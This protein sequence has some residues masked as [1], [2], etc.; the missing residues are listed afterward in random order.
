MTLH[1]SNPKLIIFACWPKNG[2]GVGEMALY[3]LVASPT[4]ILCTKG[5]YWPLTLAA[6][7]GE[8]KGL[9]T[10]QA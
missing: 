2:P 6:L 4:T 8:L 1:T 10:T 9:I 5:K 7:N 3:G